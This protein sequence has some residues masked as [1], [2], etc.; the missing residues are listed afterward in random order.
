M[1]LMRYLRPDRSQVGWEH[2]LRAVLM[3]VF[4]IYLAFTFKD[5]TGSGGDFP[6]ITSECV[7]IENLLQDSTFQSAYAFSFAVAVLL[8]FATNISIWFLH[9]RWPSRI[10]VGLFRF[11]NMPGQ[12]DDPL[13]GLKPHQPYFVS[14]QDGQVYLGL[15]IAHTR[16][17][18]A[19]DRTLVFQVFLSGRRVDTP[20]SYVRYNYVSPYT[21]HRKTY[22]P[23]DSILSISEFRFDGFMNTVTRG[24]S[25]LSR[26]DIRRLWTNFLQCGYMRYEDFFPESP[27]YVFR[28]EP[29]ISDNFSSPAREPPSR[30]R[31]KK[32]S[33]IKKRST[34]RE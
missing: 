17:P 30:P 19:E 27:N 34:K 18:D 31:P 3:G 26:S 29:P 33:A 15:Y 5:M 20:R 28:D 22:I 25:E 4:S 21:A 6:C 13:L 14:L 24:Y 10:L 11:K 1:L 16:D 8:A 7:S 23:F 12:T 2:L 9:L 32:K